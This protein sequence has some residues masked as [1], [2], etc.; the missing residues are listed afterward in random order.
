[1]DPD[2]SFNAVELIIPQE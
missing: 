1:M 2:N